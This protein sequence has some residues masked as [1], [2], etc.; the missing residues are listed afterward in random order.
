MLPLCEAW[1]LSYADF[2]LRHGLLGVRTIL[3]SYRFITSSNSSAI[4]AATGKSSGI[5]R[6][7]VG[8]T[9]KT[10]EGLSVI[11][12][13]LKRIHNQQKIGT[14]I[15][16]PDKSVC[17]V[18]G[19]HQVPV[20]VVTSNHKKLYARTV[21]SLSKVSLCDAGD[22]MT[23]MVDLQNQ[24]ISMGCTICAHKFHA[25]CFQ[26]YFCSPVTTPMTCPACS[27][28]CLAHR[29]ISTPVYTVAA[30]PKQSPN[31]TRGFNREKVPSGNAPLGRSKPVP[32]QEGRGQN[33]SPE[34]GKGR[35]T[36]ASLVK[37]GAIRENF[38]LGFTDGGHS[39]A[40]SVLG[41]HADGDG[42]EVHSDRERTGREH[43]CEHRGDGLLSRARWGG[44][45]GL[46]HWGST[47][48][49]Q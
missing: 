33:N 38:G 12:G 2:L 8:E 9:E 15:D 31:I 40:T 46:L 43:R 48:H 21:V 34:E 32:S 22:G 44:E 25:K 49:H 1:K 45:G 20:L 23:L 24:G 10:E 26:R 27:C 18:L 29:G 35:L 36:Y 17:H 37:L 16:N 39:G 19:H 30:L 41:F 4:N 14:K 5:V 3:L 42:D 28:S 11:R 7:E 47:T 6:A 13:T